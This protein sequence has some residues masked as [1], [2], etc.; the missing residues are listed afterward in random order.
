M[1]Q[2]IGR[3][4]IYSPDTFGIASALYEL[5]GMTVIHDA[6][7]CNSTYTTHDEPRWYEMDSMVFI[8]AIS[9]MEAVMGDDGK[10]I[11]D[12]ISAAGELHP[13]FIAIAG[14]PIPMMTGFDFKAVAAVI[15]KKTGIPTFGFATNGME[16]YLPGVSMALEAVAER[17]TLPAEE[18]VR[19]GVN[20][21][22]LTPLDFPLDAP[23]KIR[24]LLEENGMKVL[25]SWAMGSSLDEI[26]DR[27]AK[28]EV[29]LILSYS[30]LAA[31]EKLKEKYGT[32]YVIGVPIGEFS[33]TVIRALMESAED[34]QN[35]N[36]LPG[37][38]EESDTVV[39]GESVAA[40]SLAA[41]LKKPARVVCPFPDGH[42]IRDCG[43]VFAPDEDSLV[44]ALTGAE[45][46]IADP[47]FAP[48][49]PEGAKL[50]R[51]P[52][53]AYSGRLY[54]RE[55]GADIEKIV[56]LLGKE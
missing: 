40:L 25:S 15:E 29:N 31:A 28:A 3:L 54:D 2:T 12:I 11:R 21:L 50:I 24:A 6:S 5:G 16:D 4:S 17:L 37:A 49:F 1:R 7:G 42:G 22:G 30:G 47:L 10:L 9:E 56:Q 53:T 18:K 27:S 19:G 44:Q 8:S 14:T 46:V 51:L 38:A 41:A 36:A 26:R 13:K 52:H 35:R 32:P 23:E 39:I 45:T 48:A 20:L 55:M 43:A 33:K 34:G